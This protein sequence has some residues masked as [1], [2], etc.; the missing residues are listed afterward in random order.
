MSPNHPAGSK[1]HYCQLCAQGRRK[2][3]LLP[4]G[5]DKAVLACP[6]CDP[7]LFIPNLSR[8]EAT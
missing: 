6:A 5:V 2:Q 1:L 8:K 3:Q 4:G 7:N